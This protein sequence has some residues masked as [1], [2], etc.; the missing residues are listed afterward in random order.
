MWQEVQRLQKE[1]DEANKHASKLERDNQRF[2]VQLRDMAHQVR[3]FLG[4]GLFGTGLYGSRFDLLC[5]HNQDGGV[6]FDQN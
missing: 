1:A 6:Q 2:E 3:P 5:K 4:G